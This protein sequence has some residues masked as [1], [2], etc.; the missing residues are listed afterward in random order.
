MS[1]L[2]VLSF[3]GG[4]DSTAILYRLIYDKSFRARYAPGRLLIVTA[5][6][7]NEHP[8]TY[9]H[10]D[11]VRKICDARGIEFKHLD[12]TYTPAGWK[13]GLVNFYERTSTVGSKAFPKTCTDK[14][15]IQAIYNFL[16]SWIHEQYKTEKVGRK[17]A[18]KEFAQ[19]HGKI[20]VLIGIAKGEEKRICKNEDSHQTWMRIA[21]NKIFPLVEL[22]MDREACQKDIKAFGHEVPVPSNCLICPFMSQQELL[23]LYRNYPEWYAR[24]VIIEQNK[25]DSNMHMG[26]NNLGVWGKKLLPEVLKEAEEKFGDWSIDQLAEY[27]MSHGHCTMSKY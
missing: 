15:K 10:V 24:W 4:Q 5:E 8:E 9:Q 21:V 18:I 12:Y 7:G 16:E 3:G 27:K 1:T 2:T 25:I 6:T 13:G 26:N 23:Y 14:L 19:K 11:N 17:A 20:N 22:G